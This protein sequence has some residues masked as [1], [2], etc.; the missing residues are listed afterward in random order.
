MT[1]APLNPPRIEVPDDKVV[2]ILRRMTPAERL[3][4][5]N[6]MWLAARNAIE[7][8]LRSEHP[9]WSDEQVLKEITRRMLRGSV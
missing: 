4:V 1:M 3:A 7:C 8:M 9:D 6:N 5:A 2:D